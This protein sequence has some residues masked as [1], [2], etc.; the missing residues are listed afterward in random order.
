MA[1]LLYHN[2]A[3]GDFI[4]IF[5]FL[6]KFKIKT[7]DTICLIGKPYYGILAKTAG[8]IDEVLDI[9]NRCFIPLFSDHLNLKMKEF[10]NNFNRFI[11]FANHNSPLIEHI[12]RINNAAIIQ[13]QPF[14]STCEH[15]I[16]YH[17]SLLKDFQSSE[18]FL[19]PDFIIPDSEEIKIQPFFKVAGKIAAICPGSGSFLKN[20]PMDR[21]LELSIT[22]KNMGYTIAWILG[23]AEQKL[24]IPKNDIIIQ[25]FNLLALTA[26]LKKSHVYIGNDSGITHLAAAAGCKTIALF[27]ASNPEV[28]SPKGKNVSVIHKD[29]HCSPCHLIRSKDRQ[30]EQEC[31]KLIS[32]KDVIRNI[33]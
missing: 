28:W 7:G 19:Y 8:L 10:L 11:L 31:M 12:S 3:L 33:I 5:P 18:D 22:L 32:V 9:D 6:N 14:P 1:T 17:L 23:P 25:D 4:T 30:C 26:F 24:S 15:I 27:G 20:W 13:Q 29:Y 16:N 21:Y 2:G